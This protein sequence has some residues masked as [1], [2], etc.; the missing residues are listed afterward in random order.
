MTQVQTNCA[1]AL[2]NN[3]STVYVAM[4]SGEDGQGRLVALSAA[5]LTPQNSVL[6]MDPKSGTPAI[7]ANESTASPLVGPD[8][9]VYMGVLDDEGTSRGWMEH[10]SADLSVTKTPGGFGWDDTASIVPAS[11]VPSYHGTSSYLIM[12]KYNYYAGYGGGNGENELAVL[13][14]DATQ[15]NTLNGTS[16]ATEMK[17]VETILGP[18]PDAS[19]LA[20]YPNAVHEWCD[21]SAVVDPATDSVL[22][23]SEDGNVYRWNLLSNTL[24]ESVNITNGLG[25]AYTPTEIGPDGT[26]YAINN[27]TLW[28]VGAKPSANVYT[29]WTASGSGNWSDSSNW[30]GGVPTIAGD[31]ATFDTSISAPSTVSLGTNWTAGTV[32]FYSSSSYTL[33]PGSGGSLTL[34]NGSSA[35]Q[36]NVLYGSHTISTP[37]SLPSNVTIAVGQTASVL[38][39]P[40]NISGVGGI[41]LAPSATAL[42]AGTVVLSGTNSY[43]GGTTVT[44]G[45]LVIA[46]N[47]ALPNGSVTVN[48]G[49]LQLAPNTGLEQMT[50][51]AISGSGALDI[52]NNHLILTYTGTSP[53]ATIAA[54]IVSGYNGG[55]WNGP[56]IL[57]SMAPANPHYGIGYADAADPGNPAHLAPGQIEVKYTLLGDT[58]LDGK[59]NGADFVNM[60]ANFNRGSRSW[61]QGDFDY[62]G[63]VDGADFL[64][65]AANFELSAGESSVASADLAALDDFA[66]ANGL[67]ANV[68][69]P[70]AAAIFLALGLVATAK[71]RSLAAF[72]P[73]SI[74]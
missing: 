9:D 30:S 60:A 16:G 41:T 42:S 19:K 1:P 70:R 24:T 49:T 66:A 18:T 2:S 4:S 10:Y 43:G 72:T 28:A 8:G 17:E 22:V 5:T 45:T 71:R 13:D 20:N 64:L 6:M 7:M 12:T 11:M 53:I 58:N 54:E 57:S 73:C 62:N 59:V 27:A 29:T 74:S 36:I 56:G 32:N 69:E 61:D 3:G 68:P 50:S 39:I 26:V 51:L 52:A 14:P 21:N 63:T 65:L 25:E 31:V 44:G 34:N 46:A 23:N 47:G 55:T 48:G 67:F 40:G 15:I 35:A 33:A 38:S 37:V